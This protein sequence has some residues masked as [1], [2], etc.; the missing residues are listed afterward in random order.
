M[1][2]S[3]KFVITKRSNYVS[4]RYSWHLWGNA[5][6]IYAVHLHVGGSSNVLFPEVILELAEF[7]CAIY[8]CGLTPSNRGHIAIYI[9]I[10]YIYMYPLSYLASSE[11]RP[12]HHSAVPVQLDHHPSWSDFYLKSTKHTQTWHNHHFDPCVSAAINDCL[13]H[14]SSANRSSEISF[15]QVS[16]QQ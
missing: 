4:E 5:H 16:S 3:R 1:C 15:L 11:Q 8:W 12:V 13:I 6:R 2:G 10:E 7:R 9:H 14:R